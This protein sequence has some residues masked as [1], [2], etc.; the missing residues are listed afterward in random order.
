MG[1]IDGF[2]CQN[3]PVACSR[4]RQSVAGAQAGG[5]PCSYQPSSRISSLWSALCR[6][7]GMSRGKSDD[8][9]HCKSCAIVSIKRS[10]WPIGLSI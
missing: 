8:C 9:H 6:Q 2:I 5:T 3:I 7:H 10:S 4:D 1:V